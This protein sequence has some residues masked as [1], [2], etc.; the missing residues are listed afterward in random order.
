MYSLLTVI[1]NVHT[2]FGGGFRM[3]MSNSCPSLR[4]EGDLL[5]FAGHVID[6]RYQS[7]HAHY[8]SSAGCAAA[9]RFL[10]FGTLFVAHHTQKRQKCWQR[11]SD[12]N[13]GEL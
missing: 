2:G 8:S 6:D 1:L 11:I 5:H 7:K 10:F 9:H 12:G 13:N 3:I 4:V